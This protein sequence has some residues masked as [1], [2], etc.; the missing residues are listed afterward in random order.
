MPIDMIVYL[1]YIYYKYYD[2]HNLAIV[3]YQLLVDYT[4]DISDLMDKKQ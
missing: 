4:I 1:F 2:E 3:E